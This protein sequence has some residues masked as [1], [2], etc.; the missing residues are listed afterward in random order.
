MELIIFWQPV[1]YEKVPKRGFQGKWRFSDEI[2]KQIYKVKAATGPSTSEEV[3]FNEE[4]QVLRQFYLLFQVEFV[5]NFGSVE[6]KAIN[7]MQAFQMIKNIEDQIWIII[8]QIIVLDKEQRGLDTFWLWLLWINVAFVVV[9]LSS[10]QGGT[11]LL[12]DGWNCMLTFLLW[13]T[14][15]L[16]L[17]G[18]LLN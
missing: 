2:P 8:C 11:N 6:I 12:R 10:F 4:R 14:Q 5:G 1:T 18:A 16:L 3:H 13:V 7:Y 9:S 15:F 17:E